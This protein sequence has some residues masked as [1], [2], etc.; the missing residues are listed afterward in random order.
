MSIP[1]AILSPEFEAAAVAGT[2]RVIRLRLL[3]SPEVQEIVRGYREGVIT[4][5]DI[6]EL[7]NSLLRDHIN[8]EV[9]P[10]Q[11]ALSALAVALE[12][13]RDS[14]AEEYLLDLASLSVR[15][16][17]LCSRVAK[18]SLALRNLQI[19]NEP[20]DFGPQINFQE[21][22]FGAAQA[23]NVGVAI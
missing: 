23:G 18:I 8:E 17:E 2:P 1:R 9:F 12:P 6:R 11:V 7:V 20:R 15:G 4:A 14:F 22:A 16:F 5:G 13:F 21:L 19:V 3:A 10:F